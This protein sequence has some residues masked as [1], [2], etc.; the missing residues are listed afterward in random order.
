MQCD[1]VKSI[2]QQN[3]LFR[4]HNQNTNLMH[5]KAPSTLATSKRRL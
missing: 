2:S 5:R 1:Q 4:T 3:A